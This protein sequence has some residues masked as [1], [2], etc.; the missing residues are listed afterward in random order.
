MVSCQETNTYGSILTG[1]AVEEAL[2]K[3]KH[4]LR[5]IGAGTKEAP[6]EAMGCALAAVSAQDVKGF[7]VHRG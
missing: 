5:K 3:I 6:I 4:L 2:S 7:F 1:A